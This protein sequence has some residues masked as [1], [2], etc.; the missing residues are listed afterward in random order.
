MQQVLKQFVQIKILNFTINK[1]N[2]KPALLNIQKFNLKNH[3]RKKKNKKNKL[4]KSIVKIIKI[5]L[6]KLKSN[7]IK[8]IKKKY[9]NII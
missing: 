5:K 8:I 2:V 3:I 6:I 7:I 1:I 9:N 4:L